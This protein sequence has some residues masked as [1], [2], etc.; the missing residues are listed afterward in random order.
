M[1]RQFQN[2]I[3]VGQRRQKQKNGDVYIVPAQ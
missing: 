3:H 1:G 2:K